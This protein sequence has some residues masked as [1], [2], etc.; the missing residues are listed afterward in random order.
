MA[1]LWA[2]LGNDS[3]GCGWTAEKDQYSQAAK[4]INWNVHS[5][6]WSTLLH[7]CFIIWAFSDFLYACLLM[8]N[9]SLCHSYRRQSDFYD[10]SLESAQEAFRL[11]VFAFCLHHNLLL[12]QVHWPGQYAFGRALFWFLAAT[13][14]FENRARQALSSLSLPSQVPGSLIVS[15]VRGTIFYFRSEFAI[16]PA[17]SDFVA[18]LNP[19][20]MT[21]QM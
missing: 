12:D 10:S 2:T 4:P 16:R 5:L 14:D 1:E 21:S 19:V 17:V 9:I 13:F 6:R 3:G 11:F 7:H 15:I 8:V 18:F 20:I